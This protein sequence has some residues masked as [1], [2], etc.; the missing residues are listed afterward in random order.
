MINLHPAAKR[1]G[2]RITLPPESTLLKDHLL[3][4]DWASYRWFETRAARDHAYDEMRQQPYNYRKGDTI[5]QILNKVEH[6]E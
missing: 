5:Q 1:F 2:I 4:P 3:G 6:Y